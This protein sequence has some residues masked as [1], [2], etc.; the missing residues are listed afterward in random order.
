VVAASEIADM[1]VF[2]L[3]AVPVVLLGGG[4]WGLAAGTVCRGL[5]TFGFVRAY[6]RA[7]LFGRSPR[8]AIRELLPFGLPLCGVIAVGILDTLVPLALIGH[9][10]TELGFLV[11][12]ATMLG[13]AV[14]AG[15]VV[16]RVAI[17]S[18]AR[19]NAAEFQNATNRAAALAAFLTT[20]AMLIAG[21]LAP[22]W[23]VPLLG[24]SW[25]AG[26]TTLQLVALGL[27]ASGPIGIHSAALTA[28]GD[29]KPVLH[30]QVITLVAYAGLGFALVA[31]FGPN[32]A[33]A[34]Y[35]AS[36]WTWAGL[37]ALMCWR[38]LGLR[39]DPGLIMAL[40]TGLA[41]GI[42]LMLI[43]HNAAVLV[44]SLVGALVLWF[45][46]SHRQLG[47]TLA[48]LKAVALTRHSAAE[49]TDSSLARTPEAMPSAPGAGGE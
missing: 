10:P 26:I 6:E 28:R 41:L 45:A 40:G 44:P 12:A 37:L 42:G 33:A 8:K 2:Y 27:I 5:V 9:H 19:L 30:A 36:R 43:P 7:P 24:S 17:P 21:G 14:V 25:H 1:L 49:T 20:T 23:L 31:L 15:L 39:P 46:V 4:A 35:A 38:R 48:A 18:F 34:A 22:L 32:G 29:S 13:Y 16:Q 47:A 3:V 11:V